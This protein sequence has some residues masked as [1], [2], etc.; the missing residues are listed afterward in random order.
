[1]VLIRNRKSCS[2]QPPPPPHPPP[3]QSGTHCRISSLNSCFR[4]QTGILL[5]GS[6]RAGSRV[7]P[8]FTTAAKPR[9]SGLPA[10]LSEAPASAPA[11][12]KLEP[13]EVARVCPS[14]LLEA[15]AAVWRW[16]MQGLQPPSTSCW[17]SR[18]EGGRAR[19]PTV[20]VLWSLLNVRKA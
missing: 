20:S 12:A 18:V 15:P 16:R 1:M 14:R 19:S 9:P 8:A 3:H 2:S 6:P 17:Q 11:P 5:W 4:T 13:E 10:I 7:C